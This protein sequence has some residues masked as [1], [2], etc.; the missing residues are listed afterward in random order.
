MENNTKFFHLEQ[1][2][3]NSNWMVCSEHKNLPQCFAFKRKDEAIKFKNKLNIQANK[4]YEKIKD[5]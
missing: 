5:K 2:K 3:L 1:N 4:E